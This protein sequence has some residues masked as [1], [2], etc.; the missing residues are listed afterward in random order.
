MNRSY[1]WRRGLKECTVIIIVNDM[2]YGFDV[3]SMRSNMRRKRHARRHC[4]IRAKLFAARPRSNNDP[5]EVFRLRYGAINAAELLLIPL[6]RFSFRAAT[7]VR[8]PYGTPNNRLHN[9]H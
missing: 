3:Q 1:R 9:M 5:S 4:E 2:R 8:F 6:N 7:R